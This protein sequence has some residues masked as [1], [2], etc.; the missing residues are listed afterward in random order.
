LRAAAVR[1]MTV[2]ESYVRWG[3]GVVG[4]WGRGQIYV[5][6]FGRW[7]GDCDFLE[8]VVDFSGLAVDLLDD[9]GGRHRGGE[10]RS[11]REAICEL[12]EGG[13]KGSRTI[14]QGDRVVKVV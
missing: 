9:N 14:C 1:D 8:G 4:S 2:C 6:V 3:F 12:L 7:L 11:S 13:K 10:L 5:V